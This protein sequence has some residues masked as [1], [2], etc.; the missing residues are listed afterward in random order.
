[1]TKRPIAWFVLVASIIG[2]SV[3]CSG[4]SGGSPSAA[5]DSGIQGRVM[6]GPQ[7]P[8]V[9]AGSPCPDVPW[10]G[11]VRV[12]DDDGVIAEIHTFE[13]GRFAIAIEPGVYQVVPVLDA[14]GPGGVEAQE[15]TVVEDRY[16][17]VTFT[18]DTGIR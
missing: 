5:A 2:S 4:G 6:L 14:S 9:V 12:S 15:V 17:H 13:E 8:V 7:C 10:K 11:S 1:M 16:A 3:A 18:V